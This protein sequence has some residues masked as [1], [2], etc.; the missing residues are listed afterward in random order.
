MVA[1]RRV[2]PTSSHPIPERSYAAMMKEGL[3][4]GIAVGLR[5]P[6][7]KRSCRAGSYV[8]NTRALADPSALSVN[9]TTV[10]QWGREFAII[11]IKYSQVGFR[12]PREVTDF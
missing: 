6:E 12:Q 9:R 11:T 8:P 3:V 7:A 4:E 2:S 1:V 5:L 10:S